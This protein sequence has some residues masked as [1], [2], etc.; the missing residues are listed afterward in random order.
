MHLLCFSM[1]RWARRFSASN[2]SPPARACPCP[3]A[4]CSFHLCPKLHL[5]NTA[6]TPSLPYT[7]RCRY[8]GG[9]LARSSTAS[10]SSSSVM[11]RR[12]RKHDD[13]GPGP[14]GG[15][16]DAAAMPMRHTHICGNNY[17]VVVLCFIVLLLFPV[18]QA[19]RLPPSINPTTRALPRPLSCRY[20]CMCICMH[21]LCPIRQILIPFYSVF[22]VSP[23]VCHP[24]RFV[25]M[26][27]C[28]PPP[29]P[30]PSA[31]S[32]T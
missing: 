21:A 23:N 26:C 27:T 1:V 14:G 7:P 28:F 31:A 15:L 17:L 10:S 22:L 18:V 19:F 20:V 8:P 32:G 25:T 13:G 9:C 16:M 12:R 4:V 6:L 11:R 30:P 5:I 2:N 24:P 29:S 3:A